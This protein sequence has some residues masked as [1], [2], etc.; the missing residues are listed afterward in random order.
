[1]NLTTKQRNI[2]ENI[3]KQRIPL[4]ISL[5][6][7]TPKLSKMKTTKELGDILAEVFNC[8][9]YYISLKYYGV[10]Y[11]WYKIDAT[12]AKKYSIYNNNTNGVVFKFG[13]IRLR[14]ADAS[15]PNVFR[16]YYIKFFYDM[17]FKESILKT[18]QLAIKLLDAL[19][20]HKLILSLSMPCSMIR[21]TPGPIRPLPDTDTTQITPYST[22]WIC[23]KRYYEN[24][25]E[26]SYQK[27]MLKRLL[28]P[29]LKS[30]VIRTER[31]P[32]IIFEWPVSP[33]DELIYPIERARQSVWIRENFHLGVYRGL[34]NGDVGLSFP[35]SKS[36]DLVFYDKKNELGLIGIPM[37]KEQI[38]LSDKDQ[39]RIAK[40][41]K[42][43]TNERPIKYIGLILPSRE[44]AI[45]LH[46]KLTDKRLRVYY[47]GK[48]QIMT[49]FP[50]PM[51]G[52]Y[53]DTSTM[54]DESQWLHEFDPSYPRGVSD[55]YKK[56]GL[57]VIIG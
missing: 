9:D 5:H 34:E 47:P 53:S 3:V 19:D 2:L 6:F 7:F 14:M 50:R 41:F 4:Y 20:K 30:P 24:L 23:D 11:K 15:V 44:I 56:L 38:V 54:E 57:N 21:S 29:D 35:K 42:N 12:K 31:G 32:Y 22:F 33:S 28:S 27:E 43:S 18:P 13:K 49:P 26:T 37:T 10:G 48:Y 1:M 46:E 8:K 55:A 39:K 16:K 25:D 40:L 45:A 51:D 36:K 52:V 17:P